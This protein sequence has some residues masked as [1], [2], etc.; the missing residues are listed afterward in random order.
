[1]RVRRGLFVCFTTLVAL[2]VNV[3]VAQA[4]DGGVDPT[5]G[6][7]GRVLTDFSNSE[8]F[9]D[10][11]AVQSDGKIVAIGTSDAPSYGRFALAR[12]NPDG[13]L[14]LTFGLGG[15]VTTA[16]TTARESATGLLI[17][18]DGKILISGSINLPSQA[19]TSF[20]LAR[21]NSDGS[22]DTTFGQGGLVTTNIGP[23]TDQATQIALQSDGKIVA[24]GRKGIQFYPT[25]Q[26]KGNVALVRY[27]PDGSL[28]STFGNAGIVTT[29]FGQGLESYA[30]AVMIQSDGKIAI[31]GESG[32][33]FMVAR[34]N[35]DGALDTTFGN[36]GFTQTNFSSNWDAPTDAV[37]QPN[38]K[39]LVVGNSDVSNPYTNVALARYNS[40]GSPDQ[41]FGDGGKTIVGSGEVGSVALQSDGRIIVL[42]DDGRYFLLVRL[43]EDG[44]LDSTF[45]SGG[46]IYTS[47]GSDHVQAKDLAFQPDGKVVAGGY[48]QTPYYKNSDF[49]LTRYFLGAGTPAP[50][51][52]P[53]PIVGPSP[54]P[55]ATATATIPIPTPTATA[56][57]E[58]SPTPTSTPTTTPAP[59]AEPPVR[60]LNISTRVPVETG[61]DV[62]IGG[63]IITGNSPKKV[64][65]R[66]LGPSLQSAG[67][68]NALADPMLELRSA[69]Q[70][71]IASNDNW[72]DDAVSAAQ[73]QANNLAPRSDLESAV[74]ATLSPGAY[75]AIMS[76]RNSGT[77]MGLI[78]VY[79]LDQTSDALLA[80]ISTR[81]V[82]HTG[83]DVLIGG[84][85]LGGSSA[86][87]N[88]LIRALGPSLGKAGIANA[89]VNP[90]LELRDGNGLLLQTN[91][92]W[93][94]QQR[95]AI[96][97]TGLAPGDD[98]E[99]A[100]LVTLSPGTYTA[101]AAGK[102]G[103]GGVGLVEVF[104]LHY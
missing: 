16:F 42:G 25:E 103:T 97:N 5:F 39:I 94:D 84:F 55:T 48:S 21:Y 19:D 69:N 76:G 41:S 17:Q 77:G 35:S 43:N 31:A 81:G 29:D 59:T 80:N 51:Q 47:F 3:R 60:S 22:P 2:T 87:T 20:A 32:Y 67:I 99:A 70:S 7:N 104:N 58:S 10:R 40:D 44:S 6:S 101:V 98:R 14:D 49:A 52:S 66:A 68:S 79:D 62:A 91:D 89:L 88:I 12:Y 65:V 85:I 71:I 74:V 9:L 13:S 90:T 73:L 86:Q 45:G 23:D 37:L 1:M 92:N 54:T 64:A 56:T 63:F 96:E 95:T 18:P 30:I 8:D 82:V 28:D 15:K 72:R 27:N 57:A 100:I 102:D 26:R 93:K 53:T 38:G 50:A 61:E 83:D 4:T 24:A 46:T 33:E 11:V 34:Y 75:T 36:N 78:E